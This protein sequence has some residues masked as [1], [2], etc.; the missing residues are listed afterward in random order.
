MAAVRGLTLILILATF[1]CKP[2]EAAPTRAPIGHGDAEEPPPTAASVV[3]QVTPPSPLPDDV[4]ARIDRIVADIRPAD[5]G[6][7]QTLADRMAAADVPG[8]AI[9]VVD[10]YQVQWVRGFGVRHAE[11]DVPVDERTLFQ[12][13]AISTTVTTAAILR[14]QQAGKLDL[15]RDI[16]ETMRSWTLR[17]DDG[18]T[19]RVSLRALLTHT[20]GLPEIDLVGIRPGDPTPPLAH[21]LDRADGGAPVTVRRV[22]GLQ[23]FPSDA[24]A[25]VAQVVIAD[26]IEVDFA[27]AMNDWILQPAAMTDSTFAQPLPLAH[28]PFASTAHPADAVPLAAGFDAYP[29]QAAAGLWTTATDLGAFVAAVLRSVAGYEDALLPP[30]A[31]AEMMTPIAAGTGLGVQL[32]GDPLRWSQSGTTHG[33]SAEL[34][35]FTGGGQGAIVL[36]NAS[37]TGPLRQAVFDAIAREYQWAE[38]TSEAPAAPPVKELQRLA[39]VY[40]I[41]GAGEIELAVDGD[42]LAL[43][44]P[45]QAPLRLRSIGEDT[46]EAVGVQLWVD[47]Q[48]NGRRVTGLALDQGLGPVLARP[49]ASTSTS[50]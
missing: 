45:G 5:G 1:A 29:Q 13:G 31:V 48:R 36:A 28:L 22:P 6:P 43:S 30:D 25:V 20:A 24:G 23:T 49:R 26:A 18:W 16:A 44:I 14:M 27:A 37:A 39:G 12:V 41:D 19:P 33:F 2:T 10:D 50:P 21:W 40:V 15:D 46:F 38:A 42:G 34:V 11:H 4:T 3:P 47:V 9:A 8:L 35:A 17:A 32:W 7:P